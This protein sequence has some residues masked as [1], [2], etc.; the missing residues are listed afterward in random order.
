MAAKGRFIPKFPEKYVGKS[1]D[2][3]IFRS[4]WER[5]FMEF[6]DN[7]IKIVRW[8]SEEI[9]IPYVKPTTGQVHRYYPDFFIVYENSQGDFVKEIIEIKPLKERVLTKK[10]TNYDKVMITI[11][12]AKWEAAEQFCAKHNIRFRILSEN[13]LFRTA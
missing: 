8:G 10:S 12:H 7:N 4:S 13:E 3:I 1:V 5:R 11:N 6:C 2:N 9:S